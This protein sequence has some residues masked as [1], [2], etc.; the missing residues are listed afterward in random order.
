MRLRDRLVMMLVGLCVSGCATRDLDLAPERPD[1]P[2]NTPEQ[3]GEIVAAPTSA[4]APS[5]GYVLPPNPAMAK[6]DP[7]PALQAGHAYTLGELIDVAESHDPQTRIAWDQARDAALATGVARSAFLPELTASVI[8]GS[9]SGEK[10]KSLD[11]SGASGP[12]TLSG[13]ISAL[14]TGVA[15]SAFLPELTAS[16]IGGSQSGEKEKSLD[17][18]GASG[19]STLS[20]SISV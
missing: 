17:G 2:W 12:S 13:S 10:E 15:R 18:S 1:R 8:G 14:A 3:S 7:P 20:G 5:Q 9:Q 11:G 19:P 6:I 16:V 4:A